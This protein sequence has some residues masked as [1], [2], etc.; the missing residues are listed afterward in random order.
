M[1]KILWLCPFPANLLLPEINLTRKRNYHSASWI[2]NIVWEFSKVKNIDFHVIFLNAHIARD[3][4]IKKNGITFHVI[5]RGIK[6]LNIGYPK[7]FRIDLYTFFLVDIIKLRKKINEINPDI[8]HSYG[9]EVPYGITSQFIKYPVIYSIQGLM[10]EMSKKYPM[11][12]NYWFMSKIENYI[13]KK[14]KYFIS[15]SNY[16]TQYI[17]KQTKNKIIFETYYAVNSVFFFKEKASNIENNIIFLGSINDKNKGFNILLK[18]FIKIIKNGYNYNL[19]VIGGGD[20]F[21]SKYKKIIN[22]Y[23]I[24]GYIKYLG[25]LSQEKIAEVFSYSKILVVPSFIESYSMTVAE[26]LSS[27]LCVIASNTTGINSLITNNYNGILFETGNS[28]DLFEKILLVISN[29]ILLKNMSSN[30][31]S[32]AKENFTPKKILENHL[33]IYKKIIF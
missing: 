1:L 5:K 18:S 12:I 33:N 6:F 4:T 19:I 2:V 8:V 25:Y 20:P 13:L 22:E 7:W 23:N 28:D 24:Q 30:A 21:K 11:N 27:G 29:D 10:K 3:Q 17:Q 9:S 31:K 15:Q 26:G 16:V 14:N 32:F